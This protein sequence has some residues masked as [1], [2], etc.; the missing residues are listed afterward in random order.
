MDK[1]IL[2]NKYSKVCLE[3]KYL[4]EVLGEEKFSD[5]ELKNNSSELQ[6]GLHALKTMSNQL[7]EDVIDESL[8]R[9]SYRKFKENAPTFMK[10]LLEFYINYE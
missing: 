6:K 2:D 3:S 5:F 4:L 1:D 9:S 10:E 7:K 8:V